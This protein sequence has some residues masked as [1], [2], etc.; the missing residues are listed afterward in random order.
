[1]TLSACLSGINSNQF[2][3]SRQP[4]IRATRIA[5]NWDSILFIFVGK[6]GA[7]IF[8]NINV[9]A[10][11]ITGH[12]LLAKFWLFA[13]FSLASQYRCNNNNIKIEK[14]LEDVF[15]PYKISARV[16]L[17]RLDFGMKK[18]KGRGGVKL[19]VF[20]RQKRDASQAD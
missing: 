18:I 3:R 12:S 11:D 1:M 9:N 6:Y 8:M 7:L 5:V 2:F 19:F 16:L 13:N 17:T 14:G 10:A 4:F 20:F 15:I